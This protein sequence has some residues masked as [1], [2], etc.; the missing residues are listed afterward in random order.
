MEFKNKIT[1]YFFVFRNFEVCIYC[2]RGLQD[3]NNRDQRGT[4]EASNL[5]HCWTGGKIFS[6]Q[7]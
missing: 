6:K 2:R 5:G 1:L 7:K 3:T 4:S